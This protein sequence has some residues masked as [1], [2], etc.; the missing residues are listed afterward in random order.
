M[1]LVSPAPHRCSPPSCWPGQPRTSSRCTHSTAP[2][3]SASFA[4]R[5]S[6]RGTQPSACGQRQ[7]WWG[8]GGAPAPAAGKHRRCMRT[9]VLARARTHAHPPAEVACGADSAGRV[10]AQLAARQAALR[11]A[12]QVACQV[13]A[14]VLEVAQLV[15]LPADAQRALSCPAVP[16]K[17]QQWRSPGW[18]WRPWWATW[19]VGAHVRGCVRPT[20]IMPHAAHPPRPHAL[21]HLPQPLQVPA[22][23]KALA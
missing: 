10:V 22:T 15:G 1:R 6:G 13:R 14:R 3:P 16:F 20:A 11:V 21:L 5:P 17:E 4:C 8:G 7:R 18:D 9:L 2:W 12:R 19:G 23:A